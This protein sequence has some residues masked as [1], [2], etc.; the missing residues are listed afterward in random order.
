MSKLQEVNRIA[1]YIRVNGSVAPL[2]F[3]DI[4]DVGFVCIGDFEVSVIL[5]MLMKLEL[6]EESYVD[7]RGWMFQWI[8]EK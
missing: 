6:V 7:K 8:G 3:S 5:D 1:D 4:A 2:S